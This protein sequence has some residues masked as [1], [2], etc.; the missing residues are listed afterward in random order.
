MK[1]FLLSALLWALLLW[2]SSPA[3]SNPAR[4]ISVDLLGNGLKIIT[5][6]D[7]KDPIITFQVWYRVG[8]INEIT[9]KT[10]LAHLTEHMMFKGSKKYPKGEVSKTVSRHGGNENAFTS[11]DY[12]AYFQKF[13][14]EKLPISLDIESDRMVNMVVDPA[15]FLLE[16]DV[17]MEER[18]QRTDDNPTSA[19][20]EE[21]YSAA[22]KVHPYRNPTIGWMNDLKNL[23]HED[24]IDWYKTYYVPNNATII[25]VGDFDRKEA[26]KEIKKYFD[27]IPRG[28]TPPVMTIREPEQKGERRVWVKK[29]AQ[30]PFLFAGYKTP[31]IGH[32]DEYAL[33]I[34]ANVLSA[35]KS[36]RLY[37]SLVYDKQIALYAGGS[38]DGLSKGPSLFY[39]Y[40]GVKPGVKTEEV[41]KALYEE[42]EKI[43]KDGISSK[44]LQKAKNQVEA[45]FI[46]AQDSIFYQAMTLG[47]LDGAGMN[48]TYLDNYIESIRKVRAE[49]VKRVA[50]AYFVQDKRTVGILVPVKKDIK[51]EAINET[52]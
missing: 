19:V 18:R 47:R 38:Y 10:G 35:G 40:A 52:N 14:K 12:T 8:G 3:W 28:K 39:F 43:K 25:L 30:L 26:L 32:P 41:E 50:T 6:V 2:G 15:E 9:G 48:Y 29:E 49:D 31:K 24:L 33:E 51:K 20:V 11:Q 17:V 22:F 36:S 45:A 27:A 5:V 37:R 7:R 13:A 21:M 42:L 23:T 16:R 34:L 1:N 44:E 4:D 46:M